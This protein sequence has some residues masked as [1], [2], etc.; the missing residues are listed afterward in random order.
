M[1][2]S[3]EML[4][5]PDA[6]GDMPPSVKLVVFS[7]AV[8]GAQTQREIVETT[9]LARRT[10]RTAFDRALDVGIVERQ[11]NVHDPRQ[12]VYSLDSA[13]DVMAGIERD[14]EGVPVQS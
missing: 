1:G 2:I 14:I 11:V 9:G 3:Q 10:V 5:V 6:V 13:V 7:L 4:C 8:N 12:V